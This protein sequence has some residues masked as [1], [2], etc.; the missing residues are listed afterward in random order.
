MS[1][2]AARKPSLS[3]RLVAAL[4]AFA[5]VVT[6]FVLLGAGASAA[7]EA[8]SG[9]SV[10][11][12]QAD[13]PPGAL[14]TLSGSG[15]QPGEQVHVTVNDDQGQT[16]QRDVDLVA[17]DTG[18]ISDSFNLPDWFV[19]TYA[20]VATG[21]T[22]GEVRSSF[23]DSNVT[24]SSSPVQTG[25]NEVKFTLGYVNYGGG[26]T[27]DTT[28]STTGTSGS[29]TV[30]ST[31]GSNGDLFSTGLGSKQSL[32]LTAAATAIQPSGWV[33]DHWVVD[34][35]SAGTDLTIPC[36][37][38]TTST[39]SVQAVYKAPPVA[40]TST[41][42]TSSAASSTYGDSVKF[43]AT[44]APSP[45]GAG[46]VTFS[47]GATP[48]CSSASVTGATA[49]CS[50]SSLAAGSHTITASYSGAAGFAAS[51]GTVTQGVGQKQ[52]TGSFTA[53][54][55]VYDG[56]TAATIATRSLTAGV[57]DADAGKV[58]LKGGTAAFDSAAAGAGKTVTG[59]GFSLDGTAAG[60]YVLASTTLTTTAKI[61]QQGVTIGFTAGNK[62]YD[63]T[64]T[65]TIQSSSITSGQVAGDDLTV[66]G[67]TAA[68]G[69]KDAGTDKTVTASG[70][71]LGGTAKDNYVVSSVAST[72]ASITAKPITG[73]FTAAN[74]TYDRTTAA[75]VT[76]RSLDGV[77]GQDVVSLAG[78]DAA[79]ADR[80]VGSGKTVTLTGASLTG[81]DAQNYSLTSVSDAK[82]DVTPK[83]VDG[84]F[85]AGNKTYDGNASASIGG[86]SL[87]G[88]IDGDTVSLTGG[89]ASFAD[90]AAG[91]DKTVT[92]SGFTLG[93]A[94]AG[95]YS[96][97]TDSLTTNADITPRTVTGNFSAADKVYDGTTTA[98]V[99]TPSLSNTISGDDVYLVV[100][101]AA[102]GSKNA[103]T[104]KTVTGAL[105][106]SGEN[107][108][109]YTLSSTT[110]TA[111]ADVT[112]LHV[113]GSF[114]AADKVYDADTTAT[115]VTRTVNNTI[116]G[117]VVALDGGTASFA[118]AS[119][120]EGKMVTLTGA[121]LTGTD[122][123]NY[124][125]D[126][127][128]TATAT[129]GK[130]DL[131]VTADPQTKVYGENDPALTY[132]VT[133]GALQG[134]DAI[135]GSPSRQQGENVGDYAIQQGT[136]TAGDNYAL[137]FVPGTL[138]ITKAKLTVTTND[139]HRTYGEANPGFSAS[140]DGFVL[141]DKAS[142]LGG[143][144][145]FST[146][147]DK[148]SPVG[149]YDVT[150]SGLTSGNY[151]ITFVPGT[152]TVDKRDLTITASN[153]TKTYGDEIM[154]GTTGFTTKGLANNDTVTGVALSS[155]GA[156]ATAP[157]KGY[158]IRASAAT[159]TG[160]GNYTVTYADGTLTVN[161]APLS[162]AAADE[163]KVYGDGN[164]AL[165]GTITGLRNDD[166]VT[167]SYS[168]TA[169][170]A[171]GVG[172]YAITP[173]A[174]GDDAVL[175]NYDITLVNGTLAVTPRDLVIKADDQS[176]VYGDANPTLTGS[177]IGVQNSDAITL[178]LTTSATEKSGVGG[179]AIVPTADGAD[180][181]LA[182]YTVKATNGTL[183]VGKAPLSV[184]A[185]DSSKVYGSP[186]PAFTVR[187]DGFVNG[188]DASVLTGTLGFDTG[189]TAGSGVGSYLVTPKGLTSANYAISFAP[190][191][192]TV[193]TKALTVTAASRSKTYG[194]QLTLGTS[195]FTTDGLVN[196]D[197]VDSVVL[198]SDGAAGSAAVGT[199]PVKA[200]A[201]SGTGLD[202]YRI[203]YADGT[204]T[205]TVKALT[206]TAQNATKTLGDVKTF[207]GTEFDSAGLVNGDS[208]TSVSL[209]S[210]GSAAGAAI[211]SYP[212]VPSAAIGS[213]LS[214]YAISYANGTLQVV[215]RW[216]GYL[217]PINDTAHQIGTS[218]SKFK[219]G[220]T[221]PAKFVLEDVSGNVVQQSGNPV[222][223]QKMVGTSCD[224]TTST[225]TGTTDSQTAGASYVWNGSQYQ[226]NWSTKGLSA[227][228]YLVSAGLAD[229]TQQSVYVC[230]TK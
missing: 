134:K 40:N 21:A 217:Q 9:P 25:S 122:A 37:A 171:S 124:V 54:D 150:P 94:D 162:I 32:R 117:D 228:E 95:N 190:G 39:S 14:V 85:T 164:P 211:G 142:D 182:N 83:A 138:S 106:L 58:I 109:N 180:T 195:G 181:V 87:T 18:T 67:G 113:T 130:R 136:L 68:F 65:A 60:N 213:G 208:V 38:G 4:L 103:G 202:N 84:S 170:K 179:Y 79:F 29:Q 13:Y 64:T 159:G 148:T 36:I 50:T 22:S 27:T 73:A 1:S 155:D 76:S 215:Y 185:D 86:R 51:S 149:N 163:T 144:L 47:D 186:N 41:T 139:D 132:K 229:G 19:A 145:S 207:T 52:V 77:V 175:A 160:L 230:L 119:V 206:I 92:G 34:G 225:D 43:T 24:V 212:I 166:A 126:S 158:A 82:A 111:T 218:E 80:N 174:L 44:V 226:Y 227:G 224:T 125:L 10:T 197:T 48:L 128:G 42:I 7:A 49:T 209:A 99:L 72:T 20:V 31:S 6:G 188:E 26:S 135:T 165:S 223:S 55:K 91:T 196:G 193:T 53:N 194:D 129:I 89:I 187:Y 203:S 210:D 45:S 59:S 66:S 214:N 156:A 63:G 161:K 198:G 143:T 141:G 216:D 30:G 151:D 169:D 16:W 56:T 57:L 115:V 107:A 192:L 153:A 204:L 147:A 183:T 110:G 200:S 12:D 205:V 172:S 201:A 137:D 102:F 15:W 140:Y 100:N 81:T 46:T 221:I 97:S 93:G 157:A 101:G 74:K 121:T 23:T 178:G 154:L 131:Q 220:Q 8:P 176:K 118:D 90:K 133:G 11:S 17:D 61:G 62:E 146:N 219:L 78:G 70:F 127:V 189:A 3:G 35:A 112:P 173:A 120:G 168:T 184:T 108:G 114:T 105:S 222:F 69:S 191:S 104:G 75:T 5:L 98:S 123:G 2:P 152:L 96:L 167:A 177:M 33:F 116:N 88:V 199:Y 71:T 28:C